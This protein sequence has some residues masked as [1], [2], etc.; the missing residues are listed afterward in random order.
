MAQRLRGTD[1]SGM[2]TYR[3]IFAYVYPYRG[4]LAVSTLCGALVSAASALSAL[5]VKPVLDG[6]FVQRDST[7]LFLL[8]LAIVA[9]YIVRGLFQ[10][11]YS[12]LMSS[13]GQRVLRDMR[14]RLF[15]HL[16]SMPLGYFHQHHTGTLMSYVIN[17]IKA[18]EHVVTYALSDIVRQ[19]LTAIGLL[20]VA[21]YR[22]W[23]LATLAVLVLPLA[24]LLLFRLG[25]ALRRLSRRA[26]EKMAQIHVLL[27]EVFSGIKIVKGFGR[28][29][30]EEA[31]FRRRNTEYYRETMRAVRIS[32]LS[33]PIMEGLAAIGVALVVFYGGHQVIAGTTTPGTFFSFMTAVLMLYEPMRKLGAI[34]NTVQRALAAADR[35]FAVL[36]TPGEWL[37]EAGKPA[38]PLIKQGLAFSDVSLRYRPDTPLVLRGVTLQVR[39]GEVVALVGPSGAGKTS[40]VHLILRFYEPV[41]G[42]ITIDGTNIRHISLD[43]LRAQIG[44]VSQDVML[45][46]DTVYRNILYGNLQASEE[47]VL[48]AARAA[49]ADDFVQRMPRGYE[50]VIGERG[51]RLSGGE[52]QRLAIARA[53]LRNPPILIL[54]EATSSLD[55][56]S[57]QMVQGALENLM[58]H[59]TTFVIAHR[60][61]T[62]RHA[63]NIVVLHAGAIAEM[64]THDELLARGGLYRRLYELQFRR[65]E[66]SLYGI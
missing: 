2:D 7:R 23:L 40:L 57:E 65:Q 48:E 19:G 22:D 50:T 4:R 16:Q 25:Q 11:A 27:E 17:D 26:Q 41:S 42:C 15:G 64:G 10:Y 38:L 29:A 53:L 9:L 20:G 39:V 61:S 14:V 47:Q 43:S 44:I 54:D 3:R 46:D 49:Y 45:F 60:L 13:T 1:K 34:N 32:E 55:S 35:V 18:M 51:V 6:I 8:P 63:D 30:Y 59:R 24:S 36:D 62:V 52:K 33:S 56:A 5:L 31:R 58:K 21:F 37:A 66:K 28:E 12:Y